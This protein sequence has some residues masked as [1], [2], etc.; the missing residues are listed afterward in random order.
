MYVRL[1][2]LK[3]DFHNRNRHSSGLQRFQFQ[4]KSQNYEVD[5]AFMYAVLTEDREVMAYDQNYHGLSW[6]E[7]VEHFLKNNRALLVGYPCETV[8]LTGGCS[9]VS[10]INRVCSAVY[11]ADKLMHEDKPEASVAKGLCYAIGLGI[12]SKPLID[13]IRQHLQL[14]IDDRY[15]I[16]L[17]CFA[18]RLY[19]IHCAVNKVV[20]QFFLNQNEKNY[21]KEELI[22]AI[23][24]RLN[25]QSTR[26][27]CLSA[28][29]EI[30]FDTLE[31][32]R[33]DIRTE[34]NRLSAELY[35]QELKTPPEL[36]DI[37]IEKIR[38]LLWG[39]LNM[40]ELLRK[41][42]ENDS[43]SS[44][45]LLYFFTTACF[46]TVLRMLFPTND[47]FS[48]KNDTL[49]KIITAKPK[50]SAKELNKSLMQLDHPNTRTKKT[51]TIVELLEN[52][53]LFSEADGQNGP[54]NLH[55]FFDGI[56]KQ[57]LETAIGQVLF[58]LYEEKPE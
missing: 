9:R 22:E 31:Y 26:N 17:R 30:L 6:I 16:F 12:R 58:I 1:R 53:E 42:T 37:Q 4:D 50:I 36:P 56:A 21:L 38:E 27:E 54:A 41:L 13:E 55:E 44:V 23:Q 19:N 47:L 5:D 24:A 29:S 51:A 45:S 11:G 2:K 39:S 32:V 57:L 34:V 52:L 28:L 43:F 3:E 40:E 25:T 18:N 48:K 8:V 46:K 15:Q 10:D 7:C 14:L 20:I 35:G 33:A 49:L